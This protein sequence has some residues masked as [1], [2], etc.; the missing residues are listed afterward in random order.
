MLL[1]FL[2]PRFKTLQIHQKNRLF[3][4][5]WKCY[6]PPHKLYVKLLTSS[7]TDNVPYASKLFGDFYQINSF[8]HCCLALKY[9]QLTFLPKFWWPLV[10]HK[11]QNFHGKYL[12]PEVRFESISKSSSESPRLSK[13]RSVL[14]DKL[15]LILDDVIR[16][17]GT[18]LLWNSRPGGNARA[19]SSLKELML[20]KNMQKKCKQTA[21]N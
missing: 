1:Y 17:A 19:K 7:R 12:L 20:L 10:S 18:L 5:F 21:E 2:K 13:L 8:K 9:L 15:A 3:T 14:R 11:I 16:R 4:L 6:V